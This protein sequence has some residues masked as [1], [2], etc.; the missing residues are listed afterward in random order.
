MATASVK[1][2]AHQPSPRRGWVAP[3]MA[4]LAASAGLLAL[5]GYL[6]RDNLH[7]ALIKP[8]VPFQVTTPPPAPDY[9]NA[10]AWALRPQAAGDAAAGDAAAGDAAAGDAAAGLSDVFF[11]HPTTAHD[12][13]SGWN[14]D[15]EEPRPRAR[16]E[17]VALPVHGRPF[18]RAGE[19]WAPR[20]RQAVLFAMVDLREDGR[21]A[22]D[23]AH[24]DVARAFAVF[25]A[26]RPAG[27]PYV[28]AGVGQGGLHVQRLLQEVVARARPG[29]PARS[30]LAAAY[31][32]DQPMPLA[33]FQVGGPLRDLGQCRAPDQTGCVV[34]YATVD[35]GD[36]RGLELATTRALSWTAATGYGA[37]GGRVAACVNPLNGGAGPVAPPSA[38]EGSA[39]ATGLSRD[40]SPPLLPGETGARCVGGPLIVERNRPAALTRPRFV[41]GARSH[42]SGYNLFYEPLSRD[43]SA[44]VAAKAAAGSPTR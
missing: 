24:S 2:H 32:I 30:E 3:A 17:A 25:Q 22:L 41:L 21:D 34:T 18:S 15:I 9:G 26:A 20:Y 23:L 14:A 31:V 44:R 37:L 39:A 42:A 7:K 19:L 13:G 16:L 27:R 40:E 5:L 33:L 12:G 8:T 28:L 35:A 29:D 1:D 36:A 43:V 38:N 4:A 11:V 10:Y 6:M